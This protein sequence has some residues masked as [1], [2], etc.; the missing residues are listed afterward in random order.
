MKLSSIVKKQITEDWMAC[1]PE[2]GI[3]KPLWILR[4]IG[5]LV[6]GICLNRDSGNDAYC[7][8]FHVHNLAKISPVVTLTLAEPLR[9]VKTGVPD[10]IRAAFHERRFAEAAERMKMQA[11]VSLSGRVNL[12]DCLKA[13]RD[14]MQKPLGRYPLSLFEDIVTLFI[15]CNQKAAAENALW[16]FEK[17]VLEWPKS[18]QPENGVAGWVKQCRSWV[19]SPDIIHSCVTTQIQTLKLQCLPSSDLL[20]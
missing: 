14:Y 7:P 12:G 5:P 9:T 19:E 17:L 10:I 3:Y 20:L 1:F 4:R 2:L 18:V 11:S 15:W 16:D 13:Y 8:T 6:T